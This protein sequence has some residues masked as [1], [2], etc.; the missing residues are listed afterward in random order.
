MKFSKTQLG[1]LFSN[2]LLLVS[3][4]GMLFFGMVLIFSYHMTDLHFLNS[5]LQIFPVTII[6]LGSIIMV[7]AIVGILASASRQR[8]VLA[9]YAVLM[10]C[11]VLPQIYTTYSGNQVKQATDDQQFLKPDYT[12]NM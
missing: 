2:T 5:N 6:V 9:V 11:L 12:V 7:S 8:H 4:L 3:G 1:L 10:F